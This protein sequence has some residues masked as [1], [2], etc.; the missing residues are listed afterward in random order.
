M[1]FKPKV[2]LTATPSTVN[3]LN[4]GLLP[5]M[6]SSLP[7]GSTTAKG[8]ARIIS[9][10]SLLTNTAWSIFFSEKILLEPAFEKIFTL[11]FTSIVSMLDNAIN[12]ADK[13]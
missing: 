2:S 3:E 8:L 6:L 7:V 9:L 4:L 1:A 12:V 10:T 5:A 11:G 13:S